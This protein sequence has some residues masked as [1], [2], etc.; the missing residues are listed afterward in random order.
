MNRL[1]SWSLLLIS[2]LALASCK[3]LFKKPAVE[4]VHDFKL[5]TMN[6]DK[7]ELEVA[8]TI[9]NPNSYTLKLNT[10][11]V[12]FLNRNREMVGKAK[13]AAPVEIPKKKSNALNFRVSLDTRPTVKMINHSDQ[14]VYFYVSG[15]GNGSVWGIGKKFE[16]EEA[17]ELDLKEQLKSLIPRFSADGM[18]VFKLK[19]SYVEKLGIT[20]T[21]VRMDFVLMNPYGLM[22]KLSGFPASIYINNKD[23]G[24]GELLEPLSFDEKVY[25][26]EG[27]MVFKV[28]NW[29]S[30]VNA[31]KGAVKGEISYEVKGNVVIEGYGLKI[32]KPY[33]YKGSIPVSLSDYLLN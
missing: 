30:I 20:E 31:V 10:M 25:S 27:S 3:C 26:R 28:S 6:P 29:K 33:S 14:K 21:Q 24:K 1:L 32:T 19:R 16:F 23:S 11:D 13:L 17:R 9:S 2:V 8:I 4:K 15:K 7:T 22:F 12:E 5:I 18:D